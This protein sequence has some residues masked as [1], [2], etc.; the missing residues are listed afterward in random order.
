MIKKSFHRIGRRAEGDKT[1]P[2]ANLWGGIGGHVVVARRGSSSGRRNCR[3]RNP[4]LRFLTWCR[5]RRRR[6][7]VVIIFV[8]LMNDNSFRHVNFQQVRAFQINFT[9]KKFNGFFSLHEILG[10]LEIPLFG[11]LQYA[12]TYGQSLLLL[13]RLRSF[14]A[15]SSMTSIRQALSSFF[16]AAFGLERVISCWKEIYKLILSSTVGYPK[17]SGH[18]KLAELVATILELIGLLQTGQGW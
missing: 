8:D 13:T 6:L 3:E 9:K 10:L 16:F 12:V 11:L 1:D 2:S 5:T 4:L 14:V 18:F 7:R 15:P 17:F